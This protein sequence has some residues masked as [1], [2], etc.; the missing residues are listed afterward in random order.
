MNCGYGTLIGRLWELIAGVNGK[1]PLR[2][3]SWST[4]FRFSNRKFLCIFLSPSLY[5]PPDLIMSVILD[6]TYVIWRSWLCNCYDIQRAI[7]CRKLSLFFCHHHRHHHISVMELGHLLTRS[8][9]TYPEV[10][11]KVYRDS[12]CQLGS[13][14]TVSSG[15]GGNAVPKHA[16]PE[17][18]GSSPTTALGP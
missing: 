14:I 5:L 10:S 17:A 18:K 9:L 7:V 4:Y 2:M 11:S 13:S 1:K 6:E 16:A 3:T 8:G 15:N 12:F